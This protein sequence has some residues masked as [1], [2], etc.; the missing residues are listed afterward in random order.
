MPD[1]AEVADHFGGVR[2]HR[3]ALRLEIDEIDRA[4]DEPT[5][6]CRKQRL[7]Y[8]AAD[9][10]AAGSAECAH[11]SGVRN[12]GLALYIE[13]SGHSE[14]YVDEKEG[15]DDPFLRKCPLLLGESFV[16]L[17]AHIDGMGQVDVSGAVLGE[18]GI[19]LFNEGPG[20]DSLAESEHD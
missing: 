8:D 3:E 13:C 9:D 20:I 12:A 2:L 19:Q 5:D 11:H 7:A 10:T 6:G 1:G 17:V 16:A 14:Q 15:H 18:F 4:A